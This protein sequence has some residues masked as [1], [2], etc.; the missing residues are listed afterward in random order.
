MTQQTFYQ[1]QINTID[2]GKRIN[3]VR[4]TVNFK[5][6]TNDVKAKECMNNV[7]P[8]VCIRQHGVCTSILQSAFPIDIKK[9]ILSQNVSHL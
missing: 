4:R 6:V 8:K 1:N 9:R 3:K 5:A 2:K 7:F